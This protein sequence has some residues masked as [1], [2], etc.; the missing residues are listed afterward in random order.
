MFLVTIGY[1][2]ES[3]GFFAAL[4]TFFLPL[5]SSIFWAFK[6]GLSGPWYLNIVM[7]FGIVIAAGILAA[8]VNPE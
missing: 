1:A 7:L 6:Q 5:I 4:L 3:S 2:Y 8:I